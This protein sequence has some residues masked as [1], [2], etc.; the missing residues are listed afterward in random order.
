MY[1]ISDLPK[2]LYRAGT[3]LTLWKKKG[4]SIT[5][6][7]YNRVDCS[8]TFYQKL[9]EDLDRAGFPPEQLE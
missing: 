7:D 1:T 6:N 8:L 2:Y 5:R 3:F 4:L 9:A